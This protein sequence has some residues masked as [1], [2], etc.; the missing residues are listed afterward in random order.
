MIK[1]ILYNYYYKKFMQENGK[2]KEQINW[3][4][5]NYYDKQCEKYL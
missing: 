1:S 2:T 4:K 3:S 5:W